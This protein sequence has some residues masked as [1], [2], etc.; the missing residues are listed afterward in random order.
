LFNNS[1]FQNAVTA[2]ENAAKLRENDYA[3]WLLIG[4]SYQLSGRFD[5]A[6][7]AF[8]RAIF[9]AP[10]YSQ[11]KYDLGTL[12]FNN[13]RYDEAFRTLSEAAESDV[14]LYD[15]V[16]DLAAIAFPD[17]A[18]AIETAANPTSIGT[19]KIVARYFIANGMMTDSLRSFLLSDALGGP[20]K[21]EFINLLISKTNFSIGREIWLTT[22][23]PV[24][25]DPN[26]LIFDGGFEVTAESDES[27]FG[28]KIDQTASALEVS[29]AKTEFH[30]GNRSIRFRFGGDV[31]L[32][33]KL[34]WQ[35]VLPSPRRKHRLTFFYRSNEMISAGLPAITIADAVTSRILAKS[36]GLEA[37]GSQ[38]TKKVIEFDSADSQAVFISL[39]RPNC[40]MSPCPLFGELLLD[41]ISLEQSPD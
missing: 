39:Q 18:K 36:A 31:E 41:D 3:I 40:S 12:R 32:G 14:A 4:R 11:P 34:F 9:L 24:A 26:R 19:R 25:V 13:H 28:W 7:A 38:W 23:N 21:T 27:G 5:D 33:R 35:I 37:T 30:S 6:E 2:F 22:K 17:N 8:E 20:E 15:K 16:L 10:R 1:D 29:V